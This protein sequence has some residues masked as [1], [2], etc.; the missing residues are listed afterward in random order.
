MVTTHSYTND[1]VLLDG[2]HKDIRRA[3]A[4]AHSMI[5]TKTGAA[6]ALGLVLPEVKG[7]LDGYAIRVPTMN[8]SIVDLTFYC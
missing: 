1:Q 2:P 8:V 3:R 5:P 7:L 6:S 4:A